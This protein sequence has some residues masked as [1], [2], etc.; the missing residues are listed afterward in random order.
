MLPVPVLLE[1][2]RLLGREFVRRDMQAHARK[3]RLYY[4]ALSHRLAGPSNE[5]DV[6]WNEAFVQAWLETL[7]V[8]PYDAALELRPAGTS[9]PRCTREGTQPST[10]TELVFP[11]G[12]RLRCSTCEDVWIET[13]P[14]PP[15]RPAR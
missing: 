15:P 4:L 7:R 9:C 8:P 12:A 13:D 14:P 6:H 11:G 5:V 3:L 10:R 2:V 1:Q